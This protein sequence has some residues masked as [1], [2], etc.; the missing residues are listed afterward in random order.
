MVIVYSLEVFDTAEIDPLLGFTSYCTLF[1][2]F[3]VL[4]LSTAST[5]KFFA[6]KRSSLL[7]AVL[8]TIGDCIKSMKGEMLL[9]DN[10]HGFTALTT[11]DGFF[12]DAL[13]NFAF[14]GVDG[15]EKISALV[16]GLRNDPP[17]F[18]GDVKIVEIEDYMSETMAK[19]GFPA[20]NVLR[21][22]LEDG[23]WCAVRPS[24]TEPKCK[25]YFSVVAPCRNCAKEK[26]EVMKKTFEANC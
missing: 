23:S 19:R 3:H 11:D 17:K 26:L 21:F 5:S 2:E 10:L 12:L 25:F 1:P 13:D 16:D 24:G 14:K 7:E 20:S 4:H 8:L 18:A 9:G 15:V 22:V 6:G